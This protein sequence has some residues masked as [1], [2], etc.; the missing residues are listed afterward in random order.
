M[1]LF[2][3]QGDFAKL[4]DEE[5]LLHP[6]D[7]E[8]ES[9]HRGSSQSSDE[10]ST[11]STS[12]ENVR[13]NG[14]HGGGGRGRRRKKKGKQQQQHRIGQ[15]PAG[16]MSISAL[17]RE[18]PGTP[19]TSTPDS[20]HGSRPMPPGTSGIGSDEHEDA[21]EEDAHEANT[22]LDVA[23]F[24]SDLKCKLYLLMEQPSSSNA[25]FWTNVIVSMLI[26]LSAVMTTIETIPTFRSAESNKV[27]FHLETAMV[28]LFTLEYLLRVFAHSDSLR[29][30][31]RFFLSPLSI[32]DFIAIIPFYIELLAQR[33][34]SF[35]P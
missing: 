27:W 21:V 10:G 1:R 13:N 32:I 31:G 11:T 8:L 14:A 26:V 20:N 7:I 34:T 25:A 4:H 18:T 17:A 24:K 9:A 23:E 19:G 16:F 22:G 28:A 30:L 12:N 2:R 29:M 6:G 35:T 3:K 33:D 5:E 15:H